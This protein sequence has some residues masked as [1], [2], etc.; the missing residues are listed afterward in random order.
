MINKTVFLTLIILTILL[1]PL[2]RI[3]KHLCPSCPA[4]KLCYRC[5][6]PKDSLPLGNGYIIRFEK[7]LM[8]RMTDVI[9]S[10]IFCLF[11]QCSTSTV[12]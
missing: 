7:S 5:D 4:G 8:V 11:N 1:I 3:Y 9:S 10:N 12:K 2:P 6:L